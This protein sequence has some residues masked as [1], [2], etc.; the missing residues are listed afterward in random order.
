M[1]WRVRHLQ[2][3]AVIAKNS[4]LAH[5]LG[6]SGTPG[7]I[8]GNELVA[9][10]LDLNGLKEFIAQRDRGNDGLLEFIGASGRHEDV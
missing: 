7:F 4:A 9:G 8:V 6:I 1:H 5:E 2:V 10:W 3:A